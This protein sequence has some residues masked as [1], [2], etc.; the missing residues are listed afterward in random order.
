MGKKEGS[1]AGQAD[2]CDEYSDWRLALQWRAPPHILCQCSGKICSSMSPTVLF[3]SNF[4][5]ICLMNIQIGDSQSPMERGPSS[6]G[7][8]HFGTWQA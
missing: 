8:P 3:E 7:A 5:Q 6:V 2:L 4:A 1:R